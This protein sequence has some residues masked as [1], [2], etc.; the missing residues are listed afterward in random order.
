MCMSS[1][2]TYKAYV[3]DGQALGQDLAEKRKVRKRV[4]SLISAEMGRTV[5][6]GVSLSR[7]F[8]TASG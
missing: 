3:L 2:D 4:T 6:E 1:D 8:V 5:T 7:P